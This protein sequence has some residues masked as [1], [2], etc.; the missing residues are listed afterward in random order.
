MSGRNKTKQVML[1]VLFSV[2]LAIALIANPPGWTAAGIAIAVAP[3]IAIYYLSPVL[4][5]TDSGWD[6]IHPP[7]HVL[8]RQALPAAYPPPANPLPPPKHS[9]P[10]PLGP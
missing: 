6:A 9:S 3:P 5:T 10:A 4:A 7:A 1:G 2:P 8:S